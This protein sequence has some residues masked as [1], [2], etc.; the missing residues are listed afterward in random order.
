MRSHSTLR[1]AAPPHLTPEPAPTPSPGP[2]TP[3][4]TALAPAQNSSVRPHNGPPLHCTAAG[5]G[6]EWSGVLP[7]HRSCAPDPW[8]PIRT[9]GSPMPPFGNAFVCVNEEGTRRRPEPGWAWLLPL[10]R[11][12]SWPTRLHTR[13]DRRLLEK[14]LCGPV[15]PSLSPFLPPYLPPSYLVPIAL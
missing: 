7:E 12:P 10:P 9:A 1:L 15:C 2:R 14:C 3:G 13:C 6:I 11:Q 8:S 5:C 4:P